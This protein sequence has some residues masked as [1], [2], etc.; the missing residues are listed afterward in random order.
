MIARLFS[1]ASRT[2]RELGPRAGLVAAALALAGAGASGCNTEAYCFADCEGEGGSSSTMTN[3]AGT[4][5]GGFTSSGGEGGCVFDCPTGGTGGGCEPTNG[6]IEICD[7]LDNDCDGTADNG[8]DIDFGTGYLS[9]PDLLNFF[10]A[11]LD[12]A[13]GQVADRD[14]DLDRQDARRTLGVAVFLASYLT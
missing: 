8:P 12:G 14:V 3:T 1:A 4:G 9:A 2:L 11:K 7:G 10:I 6:G 13:T 5:V